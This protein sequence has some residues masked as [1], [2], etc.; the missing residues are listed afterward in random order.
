MSSFAPKMVQKES[1]GGI[2]YQELSIS[3]LLKVQGTLGS[4]EGR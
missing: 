2:P 4:Q 1:D 3:L